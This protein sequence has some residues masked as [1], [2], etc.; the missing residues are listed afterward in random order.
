MI[1]GQKLRVSSLDPFKSRRHCSHLS[2]R[3]VWELPTTFLLSLKDNRVPGL[4]SSALK[5]KL[6]PD[7]EGRAYYNTLIILD[8]IGLK[9][10]F[11]C[12]TFWA[13]MDQ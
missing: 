7:L 1:Y 5:Q 13:N 11:F 4:S 12:V 3:D 6:L 2:S 8:Q 10:V 9:E